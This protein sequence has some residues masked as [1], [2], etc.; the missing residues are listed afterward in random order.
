MEYPESRGHMAPTTVHTVGPNLPL[1]RLGANEAMRGGGLKGEELSHADAVVIG[2]HL[3]FFLI[4][5]VW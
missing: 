1:L 5:F 4:F 2:R 3:F